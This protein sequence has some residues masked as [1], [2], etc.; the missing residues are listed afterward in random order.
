MFSL[1][2]TGSLMM[3][4]LFTTELEVAPPEEKLKRGVPSIV[5]FEFTLHC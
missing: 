5:D 3:M 1:T 2:C 4:Y